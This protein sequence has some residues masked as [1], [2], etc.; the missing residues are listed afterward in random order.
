MSTHRY[1]LTGCWQ[2]LVICARL[3][4]TSALAHA[5]VAPDTVPSHRPHH[6]L[7]DPAGCTRLAPASNLQ[8]GQTLGL[9]LAGLL[10]FTTSRPTQPSRQ[11]KYLLIQEEPPTYNRSRCA[12]GSPVPPT[13][14]GHN[15]S[16]HAKLKFPE[17][18]GAGREALKGARL[19]LACI[20]GNP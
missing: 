9:S 4:I 13:P 19:L 20:G 6:V 2:Q 10:A 3:L 11:D 15:H 12:G 16:N 18:V 8:C 7:P 5:L 1:G 14:R 17:P